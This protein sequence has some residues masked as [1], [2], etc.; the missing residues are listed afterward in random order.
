M[1][2]SILGLKIANIIMNRDSASLFEP[3][4]NVLLLAAGSAARFGSD[5]R[6]VSFGSINTLILQAISQY[7]ELGM[8]LKVCL[9]AADRDDLLA[10]TL[11]KESIACLRCT[12]AEEGMG[13]TLAEGIAAL[14]DVPGVLVALADM[15][16]LLPQTIL[17]LLENADSNRIVYPTYGGRRGH[18]VIFGRR[19]LPLLGALS[20]DQGGSTII[21]E[22]SDS[23]VEIPVDDP[24][25]LMDVD[26]PDDLRR[27]ERLFQE[28]Y[29]PGKSI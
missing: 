5:K 21:K 23:C 25:V 13:A 20:G 7:T 19:F 1:N 17:Q 15:P 28:R 8:E 11:R 14:G 22:Y 10:A 2:I 9:S 18:P 12:R 16:G 27:V 29:A 24:G 4:I 3:G 26:T 6:L